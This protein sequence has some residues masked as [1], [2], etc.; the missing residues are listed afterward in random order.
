MIGILG[1]AAAGE[2]G[3]LTL[4]YGADAEV[5]TASRNGTELTQRYG[6]GAEVQTASRNGTELT[7]GYKSSE[8]RDVIVAA[9]VHQEASPRRA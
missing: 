5:R 8:R 6:A 7:L 9:F 4:R 3:E 2:A 1:Y